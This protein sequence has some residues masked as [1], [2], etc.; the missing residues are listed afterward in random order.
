MHIINELLE[1]ELTGKWLKLI[2]KEYLHLSF[3]ITSNFGF[4]MF[5]CLFVVVFMCIVLRIEHRENGRELVP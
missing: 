2:A 3:A 1:M 5:V 4:V